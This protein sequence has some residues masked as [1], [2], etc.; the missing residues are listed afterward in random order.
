MAP[1]IFRKLRKLLVAYIFLLYVLTACQ[2]N[3]S[4]SS[5]VPTEIVSGLLPTV[6]IAE[7]VKPSPPSSTPQAISTQTPLSLP[8]ETMAPSVTPTRTTFGGWLV[9]SSSRADTDNNG[10]IDRLD[11]VHIYSLNLSTNELTQLTSGNHRNFWPAWSPDRS[12]IAFVSDRDGNFELYVMNADGSGVQRL[13]TTSEDETGPRWSPDGNKIV[14][15]G[16]TTLDSGLQEKRLYLISATGE[17]R[18]QLTG[19]LADDQPDWSPDGR[20]IVF[21]RIEEFFREGGSN[22]WGKSVYL[23]DLEETTYYKL[24]PNAVESG[25]GAFDTPKWLPRDGYYL[26][27]LQAPGDNASVDMKVFELIWENDQPALSRV[28]GVADAG[29]FYTWGANGEWLIMAVFNG[30]SQSQSA[31]LL[32]D[33]VFLPVDFSTQRRALVADPTVIGGYGFQYE[34]ME[35]IFENDFFDNYPDWAP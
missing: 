31:D 1:K 10:V 9:F 33:F 30:F 3:E 23:F 18:A 21:V 26:S 13:T 27:L 11:N 12:Q 25:R 22:F 17:N 8:T 24:T 35:F 32:Y 29:D 2:L 4:E 28:F 20:F 14:Y 7:E 15:V 19:G 34:N 6:A 16:V 5:A